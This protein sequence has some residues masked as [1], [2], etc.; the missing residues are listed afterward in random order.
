MV[1]YY[2][3]LSS[4]HATHYFLNRS[5]YYNPCFVSLSTIP[6]RDSSRPYSVNTR[7]LT[8]RRMFSDYI[9]SSPFSN[10]GRVGTVEWVAHDPVDVGGGLSVVQV[11]L[12]P[13]YVHW[14]KVTIPPYLQALP[15]TQVRL[16][17]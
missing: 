14:L 1:H 5:G 6:L 8:L 2:H 13:V 17:E 11:K 10:L 9:A 3:L 16:Q 4:L 12:Y 15:F 7:S